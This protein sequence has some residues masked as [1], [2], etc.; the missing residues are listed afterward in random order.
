MRLSSG[1]LLTYLR[2]ISTKKTKWKPVLEKELDL[3]DFCQAKTLN[4]E[5][6]ANCGLSG[7]TR[8]KLGNMK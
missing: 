5:I 4:A 2:I 1:L 7:A 3:G 6:L 8:D